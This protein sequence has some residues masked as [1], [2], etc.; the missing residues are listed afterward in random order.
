[1]SEKIDTGDHVHHG[2]SNENW[3]VAC[4]EGDKLSWCG[5]PEGWA[6]LSDCILVKKATAEERD[7]LLREMADM[8]TERDHRCRYAR[9]ILGLMEPV[10][11]EPRSAEP[12]IEQILEKYRLMT[13]DEKRLDKARINAEFRINVRALTVTLREQLA[14]AERENANLRAE[15]DGV[16]AATRIQY[17][18]DL[19]EDETPYEVAAEPEPQ[20][21]ATLPEAVEFLVNLPEAALLSAQKEIERLRAAINE[22]IQI[23][24]HSMGGHVTLGLNILQKAARK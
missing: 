14:A 9:R 11:A 19:V 12:E 17:C 8:R 6:E 20:Y 13:L 10:T 5:W 1:M 4:V 7:K 21:F 2:P 18:E 16:L 15:H 23:I 22:A 3:V 24:P